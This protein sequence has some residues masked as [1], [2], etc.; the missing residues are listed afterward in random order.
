[1]KK[2]SLILFTFLFVLATLISSQT[3]AG[4]RPCVRRCNDIHR[5]ALRLCNDFHGERRA[6]CIREANERHRNCLQ[7]CRD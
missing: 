5:D 4:D 6:H 2:V 1:M 7:N 3:F